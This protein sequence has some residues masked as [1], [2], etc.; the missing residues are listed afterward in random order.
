M[1]EDIVPSLLKKIKSEFEGARLDSEVLKDLLS[2]LHHSKASYLDANKYAIEIGEIL[3]KALGA[4]LTNKILPDG[5]MYSQLKQEQDKR[6]SKKVLQLGN[7]FLR[8]F[9]I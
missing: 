9:L 1:V 7:T 8:Y 4:S 2:K 5:K 3:S 6:A